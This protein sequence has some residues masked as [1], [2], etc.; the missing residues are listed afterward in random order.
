MGSGPGLE[1]LPPASLQGRDS[2]DLHMFRPWGSP[3]CFLAHQA[4]PTA[5]PHLQ[6][7]ET[8]HLWHRTQLSQLA[9]LVPDR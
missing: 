2:E 9:V 5:A 8:C 6:K 4:L 3:L 1:L 7:V